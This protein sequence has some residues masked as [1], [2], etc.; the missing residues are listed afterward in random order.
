[1]SALAFCLKVKM[2]PRLKCFL[3]N[4]R[5]AVVKTRAGEMKV[6]KSRALNQNQAGGVEG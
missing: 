3:R 2:F 5:V 6:K 4:F 1:M